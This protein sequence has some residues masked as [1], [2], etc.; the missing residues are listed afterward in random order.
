MLCTP[1]FETTVRV[2]VSSIEMKD[3]TLG[4]HFLKSLLFCDVFRCVILT[5][6]SSVQL[7]YH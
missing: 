3:S 1:S 7:P 2:C 4:K 6:T 5:L